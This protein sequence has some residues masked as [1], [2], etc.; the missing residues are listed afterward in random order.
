[1]A[2]KKEQGWDPSRNVG[3]GAERKLD[4]KVV[5]PESRASSVEVDPS[6]L[7]EAR[8]LELAPK[9]EA[10]L[11]GMLAQTLDSSERYMNEVQ[12]A[13]APYATFESFAAREAADRL[14]PGHPVML[15]RNK[16]AHAR[17]REALSGFDAA[18]GHQHRWRPSPVRRSNVPTRSST[19]AP[20]SP[21]ES[22]R[23]ATRTSCSFGKPR[24]G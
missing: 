13:R 8:A 24:T 5:I 11:P 18:L 17:W 21:G 16:D 19:K 23:C 22:W 10:Q 4:G 6:L 12:A 15:D 7:A 3:L 1:M 2:Q 9:I 14:K 20:P